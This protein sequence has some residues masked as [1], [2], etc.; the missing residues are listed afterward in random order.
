MKAQLDG[1]LDNTVSQVGECLKGSSQDSFGQKV[2]IWGSSRQGLDPDSGMDKCRG[3]VAKR[4]SHA[5]V[6]L[7]T[8]A[9][10]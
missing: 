10:G 6:L 3:P 7:S 9:Q 5:Y 8:K 2:S 1:A 4:L